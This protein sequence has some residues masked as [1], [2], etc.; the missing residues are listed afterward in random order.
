MGSPIKYFLLIILL[1]LMYVF[2]CLFLLHYEKA[3]LLK[4]EKKECLKKF[5]LFGPIYFAFLLNKQKSNTAVTEMPAAKSN[6]I[7]SYIYHLRLVWFVWRRLFQY[8]FTK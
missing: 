6:R 5:F 8:L 3:G 2:S 1:V 7:K 4:E